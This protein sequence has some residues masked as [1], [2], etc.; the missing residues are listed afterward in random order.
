MKAEQVYQLALEGANQGN[1]VLPE[2]VAD[3]SI[4][5]QALR[6]RAGRLKPSHW[7][8]EALMYL[9]SV[10]FDG[11]VHLQVVDADETEPR[12]WQ[13]EPG[14]YHCR[15]D[16]TLC[17]PH[18]HDTVEVDGHVWAGEAQVL[19][20]SL[21]PEG[22]VWLLRQ[23]RSASVGEMNAL[24]AHVASLA[25]DP[26]RRDVMAISRAARRLLTLARLY[27]SEAVRFLGWKEETV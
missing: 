27:P 24:Q 20:A 9:P 2:E 23:H 3:P 11:T 21:T 19:G 15:Y 22:A 17:I 13:G 16:T 6:D 7:T 25:T 1:I 26:V 8:H 12:F 4:I 10:W 5:L 18:G 14:L